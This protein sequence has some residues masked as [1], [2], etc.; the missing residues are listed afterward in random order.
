MST[1]LVTG[2]SGWLGRGLVEALTHGLVDGPDLSEVGRG[3]TIR[4]LVPEGEDCRAL[5]AISPRVH[6]RRG[7]LRDPEATQAFCRG[8]EGADL[9]HCAGLI[10]P[11]LF[12]RDFEA[13]NV[14]GGHNVLRAA[15]QSGV[16]RVIVMSSNSPMGTNPDR[17]HR[18]DESSPY[19]PYMGYGRSKQ[20]LEALVAE[21]ADRAE[22]ETVVVRAPW[23]YGPFQPARQGEFFTM[24]R[25]GRIPIVGDG[26][27]V[28]S[29]AYV[30]NLCQGLLLCALTPE[31]AGQTYWI[32]DSRPYTMNEIVDTIER[33]MRDDLGIAVAGRRLRL[34]SAVSEVAW[35]G[36][37]ILQRAGLYIQKLH[38]LSE[39]NKNIACDVERAARELGYAPRV[40]LKEGMRRSMQWCL[41]NDMPF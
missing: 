1:V 6:V 40:T 14:R 39:M 34:P 10:H 12:T 13:V 2:A 17:L 9:F 25:K 4:C 7:D 41:D 37:L 8:A 15:A 16:R 22:I 29:M 28:R 35:L 32:A 19:H 38:V 21:Q 31:A 5:E 3:A 36:D 26:D 27:N 24:I 23:F 30:D 33:V 20:R 18:F 11:A